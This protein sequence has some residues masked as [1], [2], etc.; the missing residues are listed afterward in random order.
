MLGGALLLSIRMI[1]AFG[2][3]LELIAL[4]S[5]GAF[6]GLFPSQS[7]VIFRTLGKS[8]LSSQYRQPQKPLTFKRIPGLASAT[9]SEAA[10]QSSK[11]S[12][13]SPFIRNWLMKG[14]C[15]ASS[16]AT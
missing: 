5:S 13:P 11:S 9:L 8:P 3:F 16:V 6:S 1:S 14:A 10:C 2:P 12:V 7:V 4:N 15:S